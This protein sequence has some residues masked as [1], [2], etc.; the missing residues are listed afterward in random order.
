MKKIWIVV[1]AVALVVL[2]FALMGCNAPPPAQSGFNL[3]FRY[4]VG[5]RNELNTFK[6]TYTRDMVQDPSIT[7]PLSLTKD[8]LDKIYQKMVE[9]DFFSYPDEFS[10]SVPPGDSIGMVTPY[11]S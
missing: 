1:A 3:I 9:I 6:G 11:S 4:G 5:A 10:V 7:I 8:D 2:I